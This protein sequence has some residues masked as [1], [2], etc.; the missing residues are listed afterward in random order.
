MHERRALYP[1]GRYGALR[2]V[3][4]AIKRQ[5]Q[6][7]L[8][9]LFAIILHGGDDIVLPRGHRALRWRGRR[10]GTGREDVK[11]VCGRK[12][13]RNDAIFSE[14]SSH[15]GD[16]SPL[17][18]IVKWPFTAKDL[19]FSLPVVVA[20]IGLVPA[21]PPHFPSAR[22]AAVFSFFLFCLS[23]FFSLPLILHKTQSSVHVCNLKS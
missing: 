16:V 7:R 13:G 4:A 6:K 5:S 8:S 15:K 2:G 21:I 3:R 14:T 11:A 23:F 10:R 1:A 18:R 22:L 9:A 20:P 17:P 12:G 19:G